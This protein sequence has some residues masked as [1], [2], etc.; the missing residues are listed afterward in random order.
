MYS[1]SGP[2]EGSGQLGLERQYITYS[3]DWTPG[4]GTYI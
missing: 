1:K 2:Q 3:I 4:E